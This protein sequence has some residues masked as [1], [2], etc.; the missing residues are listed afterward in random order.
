M[1]YR[2]YTV[3][4]I[5]AV[6]T[7][8]VVA[9]EFLDEEYPPLPS[10]SPHD[11]N[12]YTLGRIG[13]HNVVIASLPKGKYGLTSAAT[14]AKDL[15]R[16]FES[17]RFGL[18]VG[19]GGGVPS[20]KH[21]IRL[22]D[23]VVSM[24]V[25]QTGGVIYYE[26]GKAVQERKFQR[27]GSLNSPP[28][29]LLT[30]LN[31]ISAQHERK[32][33]NIARSVSEMVTRNPRLRRKYERPNTEDDRL[34]EATYVHVDVNQDCR[35]ACSHSIPPLMMR[36]ERTK[37]DDDPVVHYGLIASADRLIKDATIRDALA[38]EEE[39]LCFEMEAAGLMD[40]FP[41]VVIRGICD[42]SDT[43][44]NDHWQGYAAATAAAYAMELLHAV[45]G[46]QVVRTKT[47]VEFKFYVKAPVLWPLRQR[48]PA[49]QE[50]RGRVAW[51]FVSA[52]N[53]SQWPSS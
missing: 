11:S 37:E 47:V 16:S 18:M 28:P 3:G 32:G 46:S 35:T 31:K 10:Q 7:E 12:T 42:Y 25:A 23:V 17:I 49:S 52:N 45:P 34:Y 1:E 2:D 48:R 40:N 36:E 39:I 33:H 22:G 14:V 8:Y 5:C 27:T 21:D 41:C 30:A 19:I 26:F 44:K 6:Q 43:H 15:L 38:A 53:G 24:P 9:C 50:A 29:A 13:E 51:Q 4:W 20:L